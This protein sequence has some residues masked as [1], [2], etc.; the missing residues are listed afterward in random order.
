M[1][2]KK[3]SIKYFKKNIKK[4]LKKNSEKIKFIIITILCT[5]SFS[6]L[7][8]LIVIN[9]NQSIK[10]EFYDVYGNWGTSNECGE[11]Q[12]GSLACLVNNNFVSVKQYSRIEKGVDKN[13]FWKK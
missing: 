10:Y 7:A 9:S 8:L 2:K 3:Y 11:V 4:Y 13:V 6:Y 5:I 1:E 12:T